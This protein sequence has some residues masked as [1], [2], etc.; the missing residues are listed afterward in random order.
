[1]KEIKNDS[2]V[3]RIC[4]YVGIAQMVGAAIWYLYRALTLI[5]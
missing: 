2:R 4:V 1:M 5:H 3:V